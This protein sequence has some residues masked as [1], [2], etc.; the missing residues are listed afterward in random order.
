[1][2]TQRREDLDARLRAANVARR[3]DD[4]FFEALADL[5]AA[6][7]KTPPRRRP[8]AARVTSIALSTGLVLS[9]GAV[10]S[11]LM[12]IKS[13]AHQRPEPRPAA[14]VHLNQSAAPAGVEATGAS[15]DGPGGQAQATVDPGR[16]DQGRETA[17]DAPQPTGN[18]YGLHGQTPQ[19]N[20]NDHRPHH[21][22]RH[23][24]GHS[25]QVPDNPQDTAPG[26][27][28]PRPFG[29]PARQP[30][31][32]QQDDREVHAPASLGGPRER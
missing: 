30:G 2:A 16:A 13:D 1:V 9:G 31:Q 10:A 6:S 20:A 4:A 21:P 15:T 25:G 14:T 26:Q 18:A 24:D 7:E 3:H 8:T 32:G 29:P 17:D 12:L 22:Q 19:G 27:T 11:A 23:A 28:D 5:A